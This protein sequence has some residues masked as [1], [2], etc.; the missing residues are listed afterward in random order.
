M[1]AAVV[2]SIFFTRLFVA[3]PLALLV[4][5]FVSM[6]SV[7]S[8]AS[9]WGRLAAAFPDRAGGPP[10]LPPVK[11]FDR[12]TGKVGGVRYKSC[13]TAVRSAE[14]LRLSVSVPFGFAHPPVLIPW[15]A[16]H[17]PMSR[18]TWFVDRIVVEVGRPTVATLEL[19]SEV[20]A[21]VAL[22]ATA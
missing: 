15:A 7:L 14:G 21:G 13:L 12:L 1:P 3:L 17:N 8:H 19:P 16:L 2:L 20:F 4:G 5:I 10:P 18:Q 6:A 22:G 9:G 11:R